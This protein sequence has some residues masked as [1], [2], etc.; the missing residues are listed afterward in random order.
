MSDIFTIHSASLPVG[1]R[2]IG[3]RGTEALS[4]PYV[5]EVFLQITGPDAHS[6]ELDD[7][8]GA[9]ACLT[10]SRDD[11]RPPFLFA[12]IFSEAALLHE[13]EERAVV[14]AVLVPQLWQLS[15]T[16]HSRIFTRQSVPDV[17]RAVLEDSGLSSDDFVFRLSQ[18]Y[19]PEEHVCQF[20]ES[21]LDFISR[22]LER[23]GLYYFFEHEEGGEKLVITDHKSFHKELASDPVRYFPQA[24]KDATA[25][26]HLRTFTCRKRQLPAAVRFK[27]YDYNK[28]TLDVSGTERVSS[29]GLGEIHLHGARLFT[30]DTAKRLAKLRSEALQ[31]QERVFQGT[32][33]ALYLRPGNTFA[34]TDHPRAA[35]DT[36]YLATEVEHHGN[37]LAGSGD[38]RELTGLDGDDVYRADVTAITAEVQFRPP[39]QTTWPRIYGTEH[40]VIDGE[41]DSEYAQIDDHGRYLVRFAFDESDLKDGKASTW[42][43]MMQPHGGGIEG[44]HFPL[45]K[46]TEVL[47]TFLGGDP[48][49]PVIAGVVPNALTPSPVTRANHTQNVIKTGGGSS[50]VMDDR[51]QQQYI[52]TFVQVGN[53]GHHMGH[54]APLEAPVPSGNP[55]GP[56]ETVSLAVTYGVQTDQSAAF[57]VGGHWWQRVVGNYYLD[58]G[59]VSR[60]RFGG[61]HALFVGADATEFY[62]STRNTTMVG[63]YKQRV[64]GAVTHAFESGWTRNVTGTVMENVEGSLTENLVGPRHTNIS[65]AWTQTIGGGVKQTITG[66]EQH[67]KLDAH[68]GLTVGAASDTY[69]GVKNSNFLGGQASLTVGAFLSLKASGEVNVSVGGSASLKLANELSIAAGIRVAMSAGVDAKFV[70]GIS[71][72]VAPAAIKTINN[73]IK[74]IG[75]SILTGGSLIMM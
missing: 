30:P 53:T 18:D 74:A 34:L 31:A 64:V 46:G 28:P 1:A 10:V 41:A 29:S 14:R 12:G 69:I 22:W 20:A 32:G 17:V 71:Y 6:F 61:S 5:F 21:N 58:V 55:P 44:W 67:F 62:D 56:D 42:V 2:V 26:E 23:E 72:S 24:G 39:Q 43:R 15:Q 48:D 38:L 13:I 36:T 37:Q 75:N 27:D 4:R 7:L 70:G 59:G 40:G 9:K 66:P 3:F 63:A 25:G 47:F 68:Y 51:D 60:L 33:T 54:R 16:Q 73:E 45:R 50:I 49:R 19:K 57:H 52:D 11:G 35:F 8:A 65:G